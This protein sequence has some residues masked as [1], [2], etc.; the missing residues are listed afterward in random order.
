[1]KVWIK[2]STIANRLLHTSQAPQE[3]NGDKASVSLSSLQYERKQ[4]DRLVNAVVNDFYRMGMNIQT[5][6]PTVVFDDSR[7]GVLV[8][9]YVLTWNENYLESLWQSLKATSQEKQDEVCVNGTC[10]STSYISMPKSFKFGR[11]LKFSDSYKIDKIISVMVGTKPT[12]LMTIHT[13]DNKVL[14]LGCYNL[15]ELDHSSG[16]DVQGAEY[17]VDSKFFGPKNLVFNSDLKVEK[18]I[19]L[20]V[21][22]KQLQM[23]NRLNLRVVPRNQCPR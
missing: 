12:I 15:D 10:S 5:K 8:V 17:F 14:Y 18:K 1:M 2:R 20:T 22:S 13:L 3:I 11:T 7:N 4:G 6:P 19:T 16:F 9:P 21:S 23:A